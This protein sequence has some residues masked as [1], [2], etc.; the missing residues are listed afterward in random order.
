VLAGVSTAVVVVV[1]S[2]SNCT[3]TG[4][5]AGNPPFKVAGVAVASAAVV[6]VGEEAGRG[7]HN[8]RGDSIEYGD[9]VAAVVVEAGVFTY[10]PPWTHPSSSF[11]RGVLLLLRRKEKGVAMVVVSI[12]ELSLVG[13]SVGRTVVM[14][15]LCGWRSPESRRRLK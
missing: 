1:V 11:G 8:G 15:K 3:V 2:L 7:V 6:V 12:V 9:D 5:L 4:V 14:S 13:R 10:L